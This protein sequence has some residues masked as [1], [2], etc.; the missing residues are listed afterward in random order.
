MN[1]FAST[2]TN[3]NSGVISSSFGQPQYTNAPNQPVFYSTL[4]QVDNSAPQFQTYQNTVPVLI[5]TPS[6]ATATQ[7]GTIW[8]HLYLVFIYLVK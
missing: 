3:L 5:A 4:G 8:L 7:A 1:S 6:Y 2:T